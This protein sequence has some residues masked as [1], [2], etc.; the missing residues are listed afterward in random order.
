MDRVSFDGTGSRRRNIRYGGEKAIRV[1]T[2]R[3]SVSVTS[4]PWGKRL[5]LK[6]CRFTG[7]T[8]F[9]KHIEQTGGGDHVDESLNP[10]EH[11]Y[12]TEE[13]L[14]FDAAGCFIEQSDDLLLAGAVMDV[15]YIVAVDGLVVTRDQSDAIVACRL[16]VRLE[17]LKIH[18]TTVPS[19][20]LVYVDG[21]QL[22]DGED[23][24]VAD[25]S[26]GN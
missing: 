26:T 22:R 11:V 1:Q 12:L 24:R 6:D 5:T 2:P 18:S 10:L 19:K 13:T 8:S 23:D 7:F 25:T 9:L 16:S 15:S 3:V 4:Q 21:K 14:V 17:Q 20:P